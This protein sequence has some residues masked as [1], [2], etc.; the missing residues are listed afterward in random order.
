MEPPE[1]LPCKSRLRVLLEKL[2]RKLWC[3]ESR[4]EEADCVKSPEE[5]RDELISKCPWK[6]PNIL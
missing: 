2:V 3:A 4:P 5:L 1:Q 6:D